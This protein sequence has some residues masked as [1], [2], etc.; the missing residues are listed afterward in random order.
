MN[1][2]IKTLVGDEP[3]GVFVLKE[4]KESAAKPLSTERRVEF[5]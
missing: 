2:G 5:C 4:G 3:T 1:E